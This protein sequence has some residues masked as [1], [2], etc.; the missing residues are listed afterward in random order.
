MAAGPRSFECIGLTFS[1]E[2]NRETKI[3]NRIADRRVMPLRFVEADR[4]ILDIT[5]RC[6]VE[7]KL[8]DKIFLISALAGC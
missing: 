6:P 3:A 2:L 8:D 7:L 5:S 4:C 1:E